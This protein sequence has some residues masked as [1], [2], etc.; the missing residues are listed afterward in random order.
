MHGLRIMATKTISLEIDAYNILAND[1]RERESF[2]Q[3]VRRMARERPALTTDE[4]IE[5]MKPFRGMGAGPKLTN[6]KHRR[7]AA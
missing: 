2:S 7:I 3:V 1:K 4:L 5:A 6:G